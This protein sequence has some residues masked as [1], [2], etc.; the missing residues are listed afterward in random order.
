VERDKGD[1]QE[2]GKRE[3]EYGAVEVSDIVES[4]HELLNRK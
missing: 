2:Q 4:E 1:Q 3:S